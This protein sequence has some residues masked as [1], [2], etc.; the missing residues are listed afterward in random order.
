MDRAANFSAWI[1]PNLAPTP[2]VSQF[3]QFKIEI[4]EGEV[5]ISAR[6]RCAEDEEFNPWQNLSM[7]QGYS[8]VLHSIG[9]I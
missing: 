3:R 1:E 6:S 7:T 9:M 4:I 8:K 5:S 2:N